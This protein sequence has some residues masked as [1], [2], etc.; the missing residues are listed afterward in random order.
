MQQV[1]DQLFGLRKRSGLKQIGEFVEARVRLELLQGVEAFGASG[2]SPDKEG[3]AVNQLLVSFRR[4]GETASGKRR[5]GAQ[6]ALQAGIGSKRRDGEVPKL[7]PVAELRTE[8]GVNER[9]G[10]GAEK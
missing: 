1:V 9:A 6:L 10:D 5:G 7:R 2:Q 8:I 3:R 4:R